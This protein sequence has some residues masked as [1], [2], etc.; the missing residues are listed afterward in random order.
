MHL[1]QGA[2]KA[3]RNKV[4]CCCGL[5]TGVWAF[6][7]RRAVC[8]FRSAEGAAKH[9]ARS[10]DKLKDALQQEETKGLQPTGYAIIVF[11]YERHAKNMLL[12]HER[13]AR[14]VRGLVTPSGIRTFHRMTCALWIKLGSACV[15]EKSAR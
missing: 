11:N 3:S 7:Y 10:L 8:S 4:P 9:T 14:V 13:M 2:N 15:R 5:L 12:D 6:I 1:L